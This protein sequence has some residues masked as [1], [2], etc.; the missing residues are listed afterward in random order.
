MAERLAI[1]ARLDGVPERIDQ[2]LNKRPH[3]LPGEFFAQLDQLAKEVDQA[4]LH[5][6]VRV[7]VSRVEVAD[8]PPGKEV[9][10]KNV[11]VR[12]RQRQDLAEA[13]PTVLH[14]AWQMH[15][16]CD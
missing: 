10:S 5:G 8:Q 9:K 12:P 3:R 15:P 14:S 16:L 2:R 4:P 7:V 13:P 1:L 11:G 6:A